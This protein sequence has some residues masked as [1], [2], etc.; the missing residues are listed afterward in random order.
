[1]YFHMEV[2]IQRDR[3]TD[4]A[5]RTSNIALQLKSV[6]FTER[7]RFDLMR[8]VDLSFH[9]ELQ[10]FTS[11]YGGNGDSWYGVTV[12]SLFKTML[13]SDIKMSQIMSEKK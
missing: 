10:S 8:S 2:A 12:V 6:L 7:L 9:E 3:V 11:M 4:A 5:E 13:N 1:M